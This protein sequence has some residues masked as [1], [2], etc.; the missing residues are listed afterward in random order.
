MR[1]KGKPPSVFEITTNPTSEK[2]G[3]ASSDTDWDCRRRP[4]ARHLAPLEKW[5]ASLQLRVLR[6]GFFQDGDIGIGVFPEREKILI[7]GPGF[8]RV[9]GERVGAAQLRSEERRVGKECRSRRG[10]DYGKR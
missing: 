2:P 10:P 4:G 5:P 7:G 9:A 8:C 3:P 1:F 6:F